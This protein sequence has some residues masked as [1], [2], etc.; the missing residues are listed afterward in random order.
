MARRRDGRTEVRTDELS[1]RDA[2]TNLKMILGN[3]DVGLQTEM[4]PHGHEVVPFLS[5]NSVP[6]VTT[7]ISQTSRSF[8]WI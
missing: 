8:Q 4:K 6:R 7:L 5:P 3:K 1:H 2:W